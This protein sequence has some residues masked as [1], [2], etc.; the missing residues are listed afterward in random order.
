MKR[1]KAV[2]GIV[3]TAHDITERIGIQSEINHMASEL[4]IKN[5]DLSVLNKE[6]NEANATKDKFFS[7]IAHDLKSP[8]NTMVD[9]SDLLIEDYY[10]FDDAERYDMVKKIY[11]S[12]MNALKLSENLL[13]WSRMLRGNMDFNPG[14]IDVLKLI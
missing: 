5:L 1:N 2:A 6:L 4:E 12:S 3:V 13:E 7:I 8:F 11:N 9:F 14:K 10:E